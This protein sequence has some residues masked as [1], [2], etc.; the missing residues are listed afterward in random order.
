MISDKQGVTK[1]CRL[2]WLTNSL[3]LFELKCGGWGG[4]VAGVSAR[5][6]SCAYGA[7]INYG[8]LII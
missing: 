4:S 6:Y 5:E 1:R 3:I 2:S 7:Q 8:D